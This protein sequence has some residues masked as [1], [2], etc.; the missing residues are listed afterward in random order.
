M[1]RCMAVILA[2]T[3]WAVGSP[4]GESGQPYAN[5]P[6]HAGMIRAGSVEI[7]AEMWLSSGLG[8]WQTSGLGQ[9]GVIY[10]S[11]LEWEDIDADVLK[12][13]AHWQITPLLGI[14]AAYGT[15]DIEDGR[16]TDSDYAALDG[17]PFNSLLF[18]QSYSDVDGETE[19]YELDVVLTWLHPRVS[20][21]LDAVAGYVKYKDD[22]RDR[23]LV[24]TIDLLNGTTGAQPGLNA[25]F[26]FEW[27]ALR[28][29][30]K[31]AYIFPTRTSVAA[32]ALVLYTADYEGNGFWNLRTDFSPIAP[33]LTQE[34][35]GWGRDIGL[36]VSQRIGDNFS[37]NL[38]WQYFLFEAEDGKHTTRTANGGLN[39]LDLDSVK[40][41]RQGLYGGLAWRF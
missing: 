3:F 9:D 25:T 14:Q 7:G 39:R 19:L 36:D 38:G 27:T 21:R 34:A 32:K 20:L 11:V 5:M 10:R 29:G 33:N 40:S 26:D 17:S 18:L 16:N 37:I 23:N 8:K 13:R 6:D 31:G 22:L 2:M 1:K 41:E 28:A 30:F 4:A 12:L 15:G 35:E 24:E